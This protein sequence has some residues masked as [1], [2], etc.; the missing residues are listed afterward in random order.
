MDTQVQAGVSTS[1]EESKDA[2]SKI[3]PTSFER[4]KEEKASLFG[5]DTTD[6]GCEFV[7]ARFASSVFFN[8]V[9]K[10]VESM[11]DRASYD[12]RVEIVKHLQV[13]LNRVERRLNMK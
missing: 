3:T 5:V 10:R 9:A 1:V 8:Q 6:L 12:V 11:V 13:L 2:G 4:T 7:N